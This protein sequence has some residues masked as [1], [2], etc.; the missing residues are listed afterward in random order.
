MSTSEQIINNNNTLTAS[1]A[2][3][4]T[5]ARKYTQ[6][7]IE[8]ILKYKSRGKMSPSLKNEIRYRYNLDS[9]PRMLDN[10]VRNISLDPRVET[11]RFDDAFGNEELEYVHVRVKDQYSEKDILDSY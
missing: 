7:Y 8:S 11:Q 1:D 6:N 10:I 4:H 5:M 3:H 2:N 9:E